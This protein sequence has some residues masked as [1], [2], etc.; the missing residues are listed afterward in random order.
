MKNARG[1]VK[2]RQPVA[3]ESKID[4]VVIG[5]VVYNE[6]DKI[7]KFLDAHSFADGILIIDQSSDDGTAEIIKARTGVQYYKVGRF[8][9]LGEP[10]YN[11]VQQLCPAG[12]FMLRL[13]ADE[14][15][16]EKNYKEL[17]RRASHFRREF[18]IKAFMLHRKNTING[19][20]M[21]EFFR[22]E[23][24]PDGMD[25]QMRLSFGYVFH[26]KNVPHT[27]PDPQARWAYIKPDVFMTHYK[28]LE[29]ELEGINKRAGSVNAQAARD[30]HYK[31]TLEKLFGKGEAE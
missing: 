25:W 18:D 14:G 6:K 23:M 8:E 13:D 28:T 4:P 15:I 19:R 3:A 12:A 31:A 16:S 24:D 27:Y 10:S 5:C 17:R 7:S 26:Y 29:E 9:R 21:N 22:S 30:V 2:K 1:T 20:E 11:L